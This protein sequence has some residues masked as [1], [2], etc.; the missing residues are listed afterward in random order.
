MLRYLIL[1][2][3]GIILI[4]IVLI[5]RGPNI[6]REAYLRT[7]L[8]AEQSELNMTDDAASEL[9]KNEQPEIE[10]EEEAKETTSVEDLIKGNY[11]P[12][13]YAST[14]EMLFCKQS[15]VLYFVAMMTII[16]GFFVVNQT[17]TFGT[18]NGL[19]DDKYLSLIM[20]IGAVF[21][22]LRFLWSW[23]LD[24]SSLQV[25]MGTLIAA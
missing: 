9:T 24:Y 14:K 5:H 2:F 7:Q 25:V 13:Q 22:V 1:C 19:N 20:S 6:K 17:K 21:N 15:V 23:W 16:T 3:I 4:A 8:R 11:D 18:L 10:E 12:S